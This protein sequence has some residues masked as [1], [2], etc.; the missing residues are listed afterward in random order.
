MHIWGSLNALQA[1]KGRVEVEDTGIVFEVQAPA[2][3][4]VVGDV[5]AVFEN[6]G[7]VAAKAEGISIAGKDV[8]DAMEIGSYEQL[9]AFRD[10]VNEGNTFAGYKVKLTSNIS[11]HNGWKPIGEAS[12]KPSSSATAAE[13]KKNLVGADAK[14]FR[15]EFDGNGK[16]ISNLNNKGFTPT[17][18]R[19]GVDGDQYQYAYGLFG[20]VGT[21]ANIHDLSLKDVEIDIKQSSHENKPLIGDSVGAA[22]GYAFGNV[23]ISNIKVWGKVSAGEAVAGVV[24][25]AYPFT[26]QY[27]HPEADITP[28]SLTISGCENHAAISGTQ[29]VA[30][31]LGFFNTKFAY[32]TVTM[33]SNTNDGTITNSTDEK[34]ASIVCFQN[35]NGTFVYNGST[36]GSVAPEGTKHV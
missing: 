21:G 6:K 20:V 4:I 36:V 13:R 31:V 17:A 24:G 5:T 2:P 15:G 32:V 8:S 30:G 28:R 26:S 3:E 29:N 25:R 1:A 9:Q 35:E 33:S 27:G 34:Y 7:F 16:I 14:V 11:L 12:R 22:V 10:S 18:S 23:T 19:I